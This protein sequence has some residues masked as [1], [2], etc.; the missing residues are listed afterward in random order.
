MQIVPRG[1]SLSY[2]VNVLELPFSE[3]IYHHHPCC[4][5]K[6]KDSKDR[7]ARSSEADLVGL[8]P[9]S[10]SAQSRAF[11]AASAHRDDSPSLGPV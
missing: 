6:W 9:T 4:V 8:A 11:C 10:R 3:S 2:E 5:I 1:I 7:M